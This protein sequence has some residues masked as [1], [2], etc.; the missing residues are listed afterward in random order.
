MKE[1]LFGMVLTARTMLAYPGGKQRAMK[2]IPPYFPKGI[3]SMVSPF[4]GGASLEILTASQGIRVHAYDMNDMVVNFWTCMTKSPQ[5]VASALKNH[6]P[7][8]KKELAHEIANYHN[9]ESPWERA[10]A[11]WCIHRTSFGSMGFARVAS[12]SSGKATHLTP[13]MYNRINEFYNPNFS[14]DKASFEVSLERHKDVFAY[15]D[16]PYLMK[17]SY[18]GIKGDLMDGFN[19]VLLSEILRSRKTPWVLSYNNCEEVRGL[20]KGYRFEY[21]KWNYGMGTGLGVHKVAEC[22]EILIIN[23]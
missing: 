12:Y 17:G 11:F 7:H 18:Y 15:C 16:P 19:H 14:C 6:F 9:L 4:C 1:D 2:I 21:P 3:T 8:S 10:A 23:E 20:Y 13:T 22:K 5:R